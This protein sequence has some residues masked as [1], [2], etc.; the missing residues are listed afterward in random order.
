M[1]G[2]ITC[3]GVGMMLGAHLSPVS[4]SHIEQADIGVLWSI[5]PSGRALA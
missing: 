1:Q 2:S 3:V 4:L 5:R